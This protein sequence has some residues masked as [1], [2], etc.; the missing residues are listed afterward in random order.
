MSDTP[1]EQTGKKPKHIKLSGIQMRGAETASLPDPL[2]E[3]PPPMVQSTANA[4]HYA[5]LFESLIGSGNPF[6]TIA[7]DVGHMVHVVANLQKTK[8][9]AQARI[10]ALQKQVD[11]TESFIQNATMPNTGK[12]FDITR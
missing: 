5:S 6:K 8:A 9:E 3:P 2:P 11:H 1:S 12:K 4:M 7:G 10:D